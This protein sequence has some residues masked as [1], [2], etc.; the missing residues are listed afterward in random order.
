MLVAS[1]YVTQ[2]S[3]QRNTFGQYYVKNTD[4]TILSFY[5]YV[6]SSGDVTFDNFYSTNTA[7]TTALM[8]SPE[9][10]WWPKYQVLMAR[11]VDGSYWQTFKF[12]SDV[13]GV[14]STPASY[15]YTDQ[16]ETAGFTNDLIL[17]GE[18]SLQPIFVDEYV[19]TYSQ[20]SGTVG[21]VMRVY[22][23]Y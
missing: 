21:G 5:S 16:I 3:V 1:N 22:K 15:P 20:V 9:I 10:Y 11:M 19:V 14:A 7:S 2:N 18:I 8:G 4:Q 13:V 23:Y 6:A 17:D 12:T